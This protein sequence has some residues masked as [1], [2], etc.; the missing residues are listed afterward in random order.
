MSFP[1]LF[2]FFLFFLVGK[3]D[4]MDDLQQILSNVQN[5]VASL[6]EEKAKLEDKVRDL[7]ITVKVLKDQQE[8]FLQQKKSFDQEQEK[9]RNNNNNNSNNNNKSASDS[10]SSSGNSS[11]RIK[12]DVGGVNYSTSITT[13]TSQPNSML[14]S[15]F[16]GR[17]P[18][19][20]DEDGIVFI[21]RNGKLFG[22]ILDWLR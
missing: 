21:D 5:Q 18:I 19:K 2:R 7:E 14:E 15:M 12:L 13:L 6:Q 4:Q 16:S 11:G 9:L 17:Y 8:T 3:I 20:K 22:V 10:S 1:F